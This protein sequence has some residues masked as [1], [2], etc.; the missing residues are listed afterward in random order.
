MTDGRPSAYADED[1]DVR[2]V[3]AL[4]ERGFDVLSAAEAGLLRRKDEEQ[5]AFAAASGR[6]LISFNRRHFRRLHPR[7]LE[8]GRR[9]AG[10]ALLPKGRHLER[11]IVR[12]A[13]LLEWL[14]SLGGA[15][16]RLVNWNDL[17]VRLHRGERLPGYSEAEV[18]LALGLL[19]AASPG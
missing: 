10:M 18:R 3:A 11:S 6:V 15:E 9:H 17:Q 14:A 19:E 7:F 12:A 5:L 1:V 2:I 16:P 4:R 8:V 13:M